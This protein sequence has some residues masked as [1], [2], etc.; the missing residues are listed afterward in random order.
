MKININEIP[1][2]GLTLEEKNAAQVLDIERSDI[3]FTSPIH[4]IAQVK[5][6][7][8]NVQMQIKVK[9]KIRI[10][11]A[12]CL[13][14][15]E[16]VLDKKFEVVHPKG[17]ESVINITQLVREEIV[18]DYPLKPLCQRDCQGLCPV[19]GKNLN[20]DKCNCKRQ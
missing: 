8:N 2:D 9:S 14:D 16:R 10:A 11:C 4:I 15:F 19:C 1:K 17:K 5:R 3:V 13:E 7:Q 12:R 18:F 20:T 6:E